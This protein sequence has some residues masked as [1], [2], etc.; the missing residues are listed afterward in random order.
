MSK[1]IKIAYI[2]TRFP[3]YTE[4]FIDSE[5]SWLRKYDIDINI[6]SLLDPRRTIVHQQAKELI[7]Y[8]HY[9]PSILSLKMISA[10]FHFIFH[11]TPNYIRAL[12]DTIKC[13]YREPLILLRML[14][15]FPKS[16]FFAKQMEELEID[17][18]HAHFVWVNGIGAMIISTLLDKTFSLHPHAFGL[19]S[20]NQTNVQHQLEYASKIITISEYHRNYMTAMSTKIK[21]EDIEVVHCGVDTEQFQPVVTKPIEG[22]TLHILSVGSLS[23]KKGHGYLIKACAILTERH[24]KFQC[25][26]AGGGPL[27]E[28]YQILI[29][30]LN[31]KD[32]VYLL[33]P[34]DQDEILDLYCKSDVFALPC[35]VSKN[36]DRDGI[37]VVLMEAMAM[38]IPVVSTPIAGIPDLVH[39]GENGLLVPE[40]DVAALAQALEQL[41]MDK[42]LRLEFGEKGR[43]TVVEDFNI[44]CTSVKLA[45]VFRS[46]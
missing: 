6:F 23:E 32:K 21:S 29:D 15:I 34:K 39:T 4:T 25:S 1:K 22:E 31:L 20:R 3:T 14:L 5:I 37:P 9:C 43:E 13:T 30:K 42:A 45:S 40:R 41:I 26:I 35:V 2:L 18:I 10:Q 44:R 19:F 36:G 46:L 7:P 38:K 33:G 8:A 28:S 11:S 16:V 12:I 24:H 27:K 17:H